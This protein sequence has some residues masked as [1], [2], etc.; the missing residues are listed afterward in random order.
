MNAQ[1]RLTDWL[2]RWEDSPPAGR[3]AVLADLARADPDLLPEFRAL[4]AELSP[5]NDFLCG[6]ECGSPSPEQTAGVQAGRYRPLGFHARGGLGLVFKAEDAELRRTVALKCMQG[7]P[8]LDRDARRR[9]LL[10][11]EITGHL[12]HPGVVPVYG[13]GHDPTGKPYYAMRFVRGSTLGDE[14]EAF[15]AGGKPA[16]PAERNV[17]FRR[18]LRSFVS[19]CE[20]VA[21]A[22]SRG[23]VHR[24][25]KP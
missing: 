20:T 11:A 25:I 12:E 2:L 1:D 21:Y 22:H 18:L 19:V 8:A 16:D 23:V 5:I 6:E 15:H 17:E 3:D 13:L 9:F 7:L 4:V 24:D 10:E 14:I